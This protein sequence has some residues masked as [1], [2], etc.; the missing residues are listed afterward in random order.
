MTHP[1][2]VIEEP[3]NEKNKDS[4]ARVDSHGFSH[5][6]ELPRRRNGFSNRANERRDDAAEEVIFQ[7]LLH[8]QLVVGDVA[9]MLL[10]LGILHW[11]VLP[12]LALFVG[13]P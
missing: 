1:F 5:R 10:L 13:E 2:V 8:W 9:G 7:P 12:A 3:S 4:Q 11:S 6:Y